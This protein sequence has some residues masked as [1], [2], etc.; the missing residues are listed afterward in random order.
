[1]VS[2]TS[3]R[4][5]RGPF[6]LKGWRPPTKA[7]KPTASKLPEAVILAKAVQREEVLEL[8]E[9]FLTDPRDTLT[10]VEV[11]S[12]REDQFVGTMKIAKAAA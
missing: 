2:E 3:L 9:S 4:R 10:E 11:W 1:M 5:H 6:V 12:E 8:C 7:G